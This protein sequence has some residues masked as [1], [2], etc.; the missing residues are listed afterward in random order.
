MMDVFISNG[1]NIRSM[2]PGRRLL[3]VVLYCAQLIGGGDG[4]GKDGKLGMAPSV[5]RCFFL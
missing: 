5:S 2:T 4:G 3:N 1:S